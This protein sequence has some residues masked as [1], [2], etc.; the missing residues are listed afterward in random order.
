MALQA[1]SIPFNITWQR[2]SFTPDMVD[3]NFGDL[4][5][6]PR[7][8]SS[9]AV[10]GYVVPEEQT[11]EQY[12]DARILYLRLTCSITGWN[13]SEELQGIVDLDGVGDN[14]DDLQQS[15]WEAIQADS[16][17]QTYWPCMGAVVQIAVYP[18]RD[19]QADF[20]PKRRELYESVT[21]GSEF[22][23]G[24]SENIAVQK[25]TTS[26]D[27]TEKSVQAGGGFGPFSASAGLKMSSDETVI[28]NRNTDTSRE[29]RETK[30]FTS[31]FSQM[32][33]LF[34]G[35]HLGSNRALFAIAPRP[36][37]VGSSDQV[38][39]NLIQGGRALEGIQEMFLVVQMPRQ[40]EGFCV[41]AMLDTG[42]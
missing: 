22:L 2:L 11:A 36:H 39:F 5:V 14:I 24:S 28:N 10:F 40:L 3:T 26:L 29:D 32:Y 41:Q 31:S 15:T 35:Y 38:D 13:P 25:G 37:T 27:H 42:H 20:E 30:S 17:A 4:E 19:D 6:P 16:W 8:R 34:T 9:L 23:S 12:P 33:Q 7:W 21:E 18:S 1:L